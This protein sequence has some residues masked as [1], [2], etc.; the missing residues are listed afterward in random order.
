MT[1]AQS[2]SVAALPANP[3]E[4]KRA[5]AAPPRCSDARA[6][7]AIGPP[8]RTGRFPTALAGARTTVCRA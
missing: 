6:V 3:G 4:R 8:I 7:V 1:V 5:T 2:R